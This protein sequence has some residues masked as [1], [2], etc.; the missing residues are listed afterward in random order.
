MKA[1]PNHRQQFPHRIERREIRF[2]NVATV[3]VR[4]RV[5]ENRLSEGKR[6]HRSSWVTE[7]S[8]LRDEAGAPATARDEKTAS[9]RRSGL[10]RHRER[11]KMHLE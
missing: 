5:T 4:H 3:P 2:S 6:A 9:Q 8:S 11:R 10:A 1:M 7:K